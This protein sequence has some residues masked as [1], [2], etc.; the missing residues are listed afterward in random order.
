V[1]GIEA[2]EERSREKVDENRT[3]KEKTQQKRGWR[4]S[5]PQTCSSGGEELGK[6][7][8]EKSAVKKIFN[9]MRK[10]RDF[11]KQLGKKKEEKE[12]SS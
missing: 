5:T 12:R 11:K 9:P 3:T 1:G 7:L 4:K 10:G 2:T 6:N 8:G